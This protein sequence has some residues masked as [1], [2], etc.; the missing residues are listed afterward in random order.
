MFT[1]FPFGIAT[2][3]CWNKHV[4]GCNYYSIY[5]V[6]EDS[7]NK[8]CGKPLEIEDFDEDDVCSYYWFPRCVVMSSDEE[9]LMKD[10]KNNW[11]KVTAIAKTSPEIINYL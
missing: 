3:I 11:E 1:I 7:Y 8:Y 2:R 4:D 10:I 9:V 5:G 6:C